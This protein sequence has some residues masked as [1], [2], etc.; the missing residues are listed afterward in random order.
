LVAVR[1]RRRWPRTDS[2]GVL[3]AAHDAVLWY[4]AEPTRYAVGGSRLDVFLAHVAHRRMQD[5]S[6]EDRRRLAHD[7]CVRAAQQL[8]AKVGSPNPTSA[9]EQQGERVAARRRLMS[10]ARTDIEEQFLAACLRDGAGRTV[11]VVLGTEQL[12]PSEQAEAVQKMTKR[13]HQRAVRE[14][15]R[16][17][18]VSNGTPKTNR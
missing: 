18:G 8:A 2:D 1:L 9:P 4:L 3:S 14:A 10:T 12:S 7:A 11:S 16:R 13:L 17:E 6:R 5:A 15:A